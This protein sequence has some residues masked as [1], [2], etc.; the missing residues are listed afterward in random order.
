MDGWIGSVRSA[1]QLYMAER[2]TVPELLSRRARE[3]LEDEE[4]KRM[5]VG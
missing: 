5:Y 1:M 4:E 2:T 3:A